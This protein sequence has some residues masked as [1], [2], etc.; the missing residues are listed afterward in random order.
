[1]LIVILVVWVGVQMAWK[2]AFPGVSADPDI[3]A[4]R[5]GC[6]HG[7]DCQDEK[8]GDSDCCDRSPGSCQHKGDL[9]DQSR[10]RPH[11]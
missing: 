10:R 4:G 11:G 1:M 2:K 5:M 8:K 3:L 9:P 7:R 6:G